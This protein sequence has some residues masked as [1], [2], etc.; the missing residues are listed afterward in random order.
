[1]KKTIFKRVP[2]RIIQITLGECDRLYG[3]TLSGDLYYYNV[4]NRM[5][6]FRTNSPLVEKELEGEE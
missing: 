2:D 4:S 1:M 6:E 5:W 3:I